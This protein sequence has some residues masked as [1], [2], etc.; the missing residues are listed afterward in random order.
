MHDDRFAR[1]LLRPKCK[2]SVRVGSLLIFF[3]VD[4]IICTATTCGFPSPE[5][6]VGIS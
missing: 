2:E 6:G 3:A 1:V 5:E 4:V